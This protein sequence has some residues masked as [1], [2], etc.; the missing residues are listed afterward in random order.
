VSSI[1]SELFEFQ[2]NM[3]HIPIKKVLYLIWKNPYMAAGR[4]TFINALL[5]INNFE[6]SIIDETSRYPEITPGDLRDADLVLLST[7]PYPFTEND[8]KAMEKEINKE[9]RLVNGEYFSW[10]GSR[11]AEAFSY[12]KKLHSY[13]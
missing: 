6:N 11:L 2:K 13:R 5:A 3:R 4:D 10:Y 8:V 12:F 1:S 7:E 9:V